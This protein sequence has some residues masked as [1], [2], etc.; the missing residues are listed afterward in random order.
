[1]YTKIEVLLPYIQGE[2]VTTSKLPATICEACITL[3]ILAQTSQPHGALLHRGM[4]P[5]SPANMAARELYRCAVC[6]TLWV[7]HIDK[8]GQAGMFRLQAC[9]DL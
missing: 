5:Q 7:R 6:D 9:K 3:G 2:A 8:W 1:M 4:M